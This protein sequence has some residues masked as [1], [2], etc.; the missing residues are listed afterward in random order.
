MG[1][2]IEEASEEGKC[3]EPPMKCMTTSTHHLRASVIRILGK[4]GTE[5]VNFLIDSGSTHC[6]MSPKLLQKLKLKLNSDTICH[7]WGDSNHI[8]TELKIERKE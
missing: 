7:R 1:T 2:T 5:N 4:M 3:T 6:F 8:I